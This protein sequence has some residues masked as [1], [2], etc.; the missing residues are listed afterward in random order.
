MS[1]KLTVM[2]GIRHIRFLIFILVVAV[3]ADDQ[4]VLVLGGVRLGL[5]RGPRLHLGLDI[6]IV[7]L[8]FLGLGLPF[9]V[10][11]QVSVPWYQLSYSGIRL[12]DLEFV[13]LDVGARWKDLL[14]Y[15]TEGVSAVARL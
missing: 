8:F 4:V 11:G 5:A 13:S 3:L 14:K 12:V 2:P 10:P 1:C 9:K 7:G 6:F 15:F